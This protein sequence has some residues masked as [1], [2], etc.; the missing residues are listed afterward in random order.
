MGFHTLSG[1]L[2]ACSPYCMSGETRSSD[3]ICTTTMNSAMPKVGANSLKRN[4]NQYHYLAI[5]A[6]TQ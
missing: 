2:N 1:L 4:F 5:F 6:H 3:R